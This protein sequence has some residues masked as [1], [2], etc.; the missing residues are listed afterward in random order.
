[1]SAE[2]CLPVN[3]CG[4]PEV[5]EDEDDDEGLY[6]EDPQIDLSERNLIRRKPSDC[7]WD[8]IRRNNHHCSSNISNHT[9]NK[10][11][12]KTRRISQGSENVSTKPP[13]CCVVMKNTSKHLLRAL[14]IV[15]IQ[16]VCSPVSNYSS[17]CFVVNQAGA[18]KLPSL[19]SWMTNSNPPHSL[20]SDPMDTSDSL[21]AASTMN[22]AAT[23]ALHSIRN[24]HFQP[25]TGHSFDGSP[26]RGS[27]AANHRQNHFGATAAQSITVTGTGSGA[28]P[29]Q[30]A[31]SSKHLPREHRSSGGSQLRLI[32]RKPFQSIG[33]LNA[34]PKS[35]L[36]RFWGSSSGSSSTASKAPGGQTPALLRSPFHHQQ[37]STS[38]SGGGGRGQVMPLT[39]WPIQSAPHVG[40]QVPQLAPPSMLHWSSLPFQR[41]V[42]APDLRSPL[43]KNIGSAGE[44]AAQLVDKQRYLHH[45]RQAQQQSQQQQHPSN[46]EDRI[47]HAIGFGETAN[48]DDFI[49]LTE[50]QVI[51][52]AAE[53]ERQHQQQQEQ[54]QHQK[55]DENKSEVILLCTGGPN[56]CS[57][58]TTTE[59]TASATTSTSTAAA[60]ESSQPF[61][62][63]R[64]P[65]QVGGVTM[66][67]G[68]EYALNASSATLATTIAPP[69]S[70]NNLITIEPQMAESKQQQANESMT[71]ASGHQQVDYESSGSTATAIKLSSSIVQSNGSAA[72]SSQE[73]DEQQSRGLDSSAS[74]PMVL[75]ADASEMSSGGRS[76]TSTGN[77]IDLAASGESS[78]AQQ[79]Q[80]TGE[81]QHSPADNNEQTGGAQS[82][83]DHSTYVSEFAAAANENPAA[84]QFESFIIGPY[85]G[86]N[87]GDSA[88]NNRVLYGQP[89][90][91]NVMIDDGQQQLISRQQSEQSSTNGF[92]YQPHQQQQQSMPFPSQPG[93][94]RQVV[95]Q[96][97][98]PSSMRAHGYSH[99]QPRLLGAMPIAGMASSFIEQA[100]NLIQL[101]FQQH[102]QQAPAAVSQPTRFRGR[103]SHTAEQGSHNNDN[104]RQ[105]FGHINGGTKS[106]PMLSLPGPSIS[107]SFN[108]WNNHPMP[109]EGT[110]SLAQM[111]FATAPSQHRPKMHRN[112]RPH[113]HQ[114]QE[115]PHETLYRMVGAFAN[116]RP[117]ATLPMRQAEPVVSYV[118]STDSAA[119]TNQQNR[120]NFQ[121]QQSP[122]QQQV[123]E[124]AQP[125]QKQQTSSS[126]QKFKSGL[127]Q[128]EPP[129]LVEGNGIAQQQQQPQQQV[130]VSD[131]WQQEQEQQQRTVSAEDA[132]DANAVQQASEM[133]DD[134]SDV[135]ELPVDDEQTKQQVET[136]TKGLT[137]AFRNSASEA[138]TVQQ[139]QVGSTIEFKDQQVSPSGDGSANETTRKGQVFNESIG[140]G[141]GGGKGRY[142]IA[143][144]SIRTSQDVSLYEIEMPDANSV[145]F[146]QQQAPASN[147]L[148]T[149]VYTVPYTMSMQPNGETRFEPEQQQQPAPVDH[150]MFLQ[151]HHQQVHASQQQ[152]VTPPM[153]IG[154][155]RQQHQY[156][157]VPHYSHSQGHHQ[158]HL[159]SPYLANNQMSRPFIPYLEPPS[160]AMVPVHQ[161]QAHGRP[162]QFIA[163]QAQPFTPV[164][165]R[166]QW[167]QPQVRPLITPQAAAPPREGWYALA[168]KHSPESGGPSATAPSQQQQ[169]QSTFTATNTPNAIDRSMATTGASIDASANSS[170]SLSASLASS[171]AQPNVVVDQDATEAPDSFGSTDS[172]TA[173]T[174][175]ATE[176]AANSPAS[177]SRHDATVESPSSFCSDRAPGL[178]AD[179]GQRCRV[180]IIQK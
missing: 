52:A 179:I 25:P 39:N 66:M 76:V 112:N 150:T 177:V 3:I 79:A 81:Q 159:G 60:S 8:S 121:Q 59:A 142:E 101:P 125:P 10:Q 22:P 96:V 70:D 86:F 115:P 11:Y 160:R 92:G 27:S 169:Q 128:I 20:L 155:M 9:L 137:S 58:L 119:P 84:D 80:V 100:R 176:V 97:R 153:F 50:Q 104:Y 126:P 151:P 48:N 13:R 24:G 77:S 118:I 108:R 44:A 23:I 1:M 138:A 41:Q 87:G 57:N 71:S 152:Q 110:G 36:G 135:D 174:T 117:I 163:G 68:E 2:R 102:H 132:S 148:D 53:A 31:G 61:E 35:L 141:T 124:K 45:H 144:K 55:Q 113:P 122:V 93:D 154:A 17:S 143:Q 99:R 158:P 75:T 26:A 116:G 127:Y 123:I 72:D 131:D 164:T 64:E 63:T 43:M 65:P 134:S 178:Y 120:P 129:K 91:E 38:F 32:A 133:S 67:T 109:P 46:G 166:D 4:T 149:Q 156:Q 146:D 175:A 33:L 147:Y 136:T 29:L 167:T 107:N 140:S 165:A 40:P 83:V 62:S 19:L 111:Q 173:A 106:W 5:N 78:S 94:V 103:P 157:P 56:E 6:L 42:G 12:C 89:V 114:W 54:R 90:A 37:V 105:Q 30:L 7:Q 69:S 170:S 14:L 49:I 15:L 171:T 34:L 130:D 21:M 172:T 28:D 82:Q 145:Q 98:Q 180:R 47:K 168:I 16:T 73:S 85:K 139:R 74:S 162:A 18:L 95:P 161:S 51:S 88:D